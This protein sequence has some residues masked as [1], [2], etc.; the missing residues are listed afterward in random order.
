MKS[1]ALMASAA[2]VGFAESE[3]ASTVTD[4]YKEQCTATVGSIFNQ[5]NLKLNP[6]HA[7]QT[8]ARD[9]CLKEEMAVPNGVKPAVCIYSGFYLL[10]FL[11]PKV[12]NPPRLKEMTT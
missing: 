11:L 4:Q 5:E 7:M 2:A 1:L 12:D 8:Y 6:M 9:F 3:A 10:R